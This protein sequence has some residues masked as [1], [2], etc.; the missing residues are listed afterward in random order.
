MHKKVPRSD[1]PWVHMCWCVCVCVCVFVCM[2]VFFCVG[3]RVC[4]YV[5]DLYEYW[6]CP[7]AQA[8]TN[9]PPKQFV[10]DRESLRMRRVITRRVSDIHSRNRFSHILICRYLLHSDFMGITPPLTISLFLSF[11]LSFIILFLSFS[12]LLKNKED[13][14]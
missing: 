1:F 11:F 8:K 13:I 4:V 3:M 14:Y 6:F 7:S 2:F 10:L 5:F 12:V 9:E